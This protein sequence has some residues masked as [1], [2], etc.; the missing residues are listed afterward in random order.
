MG[1]LC[2]LIVQLLCNYQLGICGRCTICNMLTV[3]TPWVTKGACST[4][5][6]LSGHPWV[7]M[8]V[9]SSCIRW[10]GVPLGL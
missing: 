2:G 5:I 7:T 8:G 6:R 1:F 4:C 3:D 10:A 9:C